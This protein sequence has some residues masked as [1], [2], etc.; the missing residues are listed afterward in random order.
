MNCSPY[1]RRRLRNIDEVLAAR[2]LET[3]YDHTHSYS[4]PDP[5]A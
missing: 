2:R 4:R 3:G 5:R 1:L